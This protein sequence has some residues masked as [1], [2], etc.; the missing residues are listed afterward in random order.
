MKTF[1]RAL[2]LLS[3][4]QDAYL[5]WLANQA[6]PPKSYREHL[7]ASEEALNHY[8]QLFEKEY[9]M[10]LGAF[11]RI[12]RV[13]YL[14]EQRQARPNQLAYAFVDTLLGTMLSV[15]SEKGLC[16]LEFVDRKSLET[17]LKELIAHYQA[18]FLPQES[19]FFPALAH[20]LQAYFQG[21][22]QRFDL[23]LDIW[24]TAFQCRVWQELMAIDY[25]T[26]L[27]YA[28]QAARLQM[29]KATR[30]VATANGKNRL[31]IVIPCHRVCRKNGE[32]GGYGGG[33]ARKRFL[34]ALEKK[35][36]FIV[37]NFKKRYGFD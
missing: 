16:L 29:P 14:L 9:S 36:S 17:E 10:S 5:S 25:G 33:L 30:A 32:L 1:N 20:Q 3:A 7:L 23:P 24:G 27:S 26:T 35:P 34:L 4:Q 11:I 18:D 2:A 31:A 12:K 15:F 28:E 6:N 21:Q 13:L 19:V 8:K 22:L 37:K